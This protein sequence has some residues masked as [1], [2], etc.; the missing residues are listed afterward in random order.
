M[1]STKLRVRGTIFPIKRHGRPTGKWAWEYQ[2]PGPTTRART[3]RSFDSKRDAE[4]ARHEAAL[5]ELATKSAPKRSQT[6]K[7][8]GDW[9]LTYHR[10]GRVKPSTQGDYTYRLQHWIYPT[11]GQ[12]QLEAVDERAIGLWMA[13]MKARGLSV[14]TVNGARRLL[15][16]LFEH[17]RRSGT[18]SLNPV[19]VVPALKAQ[20]GDR[21]QKCDPWTVEEARKA[22]RALESESVELVV[23][24][25]LSLGLRRGEALGLQW[26][27]INLT[28]GTLRI[29]RTYRLVAV[30]EG[31]QRKNVG[32]FDTPKTSS[33]ARV[34]PIP[35]ILEHALRR[36]AVR[37]ARQK[38]FAGGR[39]REQELVITNSVGGPLD[40]SAVTRQYK[41]ALRRSG[42][43]YIRLHDLRH[44]SATL[45]L[46]AGE[47]ID[48]VSQALGHTDVR[49]TKSIY[50]PNVPNYNA[51]FGAAL[52]ALLQ[53]PADEALVGHDDLDR[54]LQRLAP[55][56]DGVPA[57]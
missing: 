49:M 6:V 54:E 30:Y 5:H 24:L 10:A 55:T 29:S 41:A 42:V 22:L 43:R 26:G 28:E 16:M 7:Q 37:Q 11:F 39:W 8:Y 1:A 35:E 53:Q 20:Y 15:N 4:R 25:G 14:N 9:W 57:K 38:Q 44:T 46:L 40:P 27:D 3:R 48:L 56:G 47:P 21:T 17:A 23:L 52:N 19:A 36:H 18:L 2:V 12:H 34:L 32:Q 31:E 13:D 50:A 33:S 51:Q 45:A